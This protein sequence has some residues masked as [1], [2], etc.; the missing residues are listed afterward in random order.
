MQTHQCEFRYGNKQERILIHYIFIK[1]M[2]YLYTVVHHNLVHSI[3]NCWRQWN[4]SIYLLVTQIIKTGQ[5][6]MLHCA[7]ILNFYPKTVSL[8]WKW[9]ID[10]TLVMVLKVSDQIGKFGSKVSVIVL[11]W[12]FGFQ[13]GQ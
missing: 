5:K 6:Y 13:V 11:N 2:K 1:W 3:E 12:T 10:T 4:I 8:K 7:L 9:L